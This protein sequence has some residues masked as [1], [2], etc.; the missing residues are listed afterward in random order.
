MVYDTVLPTLHT[1]QYIINILGMN[2]IHELAQLGP[3]IKALVLQRLTLFFQGETQDLER[4]KICCFFVQGLK[5]LRLNVLIC[6]NN[7][8]L[9]RTWDLYTC[10]WT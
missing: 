9:E 4:R 3:S 10:Y 2:I 1:I 6:S 7:H 5:G 8:S